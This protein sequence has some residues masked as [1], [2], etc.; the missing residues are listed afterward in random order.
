LDGQG[1]ASTRDWGRGQALLAVKGGGSSETVDERHK[2]GG[3]GKTVGKGSRGASGNK[4][5]G[6]GER[7]TGGK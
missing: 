1:E 5:A 4:G 3:D 2:L 6:G 7:G